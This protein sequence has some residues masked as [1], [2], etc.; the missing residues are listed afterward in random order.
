MN[1]TLF[2]KEWKSSYKLLLI[3]AAILTMYMSVMIVMFDPGL[4]SALD[5]F[6]KAMPEMMAMF[7][8]SNAGATLV[9]FLSTYLY[10]ML[11]IVFPM[12]F[13]VI[14][15]VRLI[16][17]QVDKGF[18]AYLL[19]SPNARKTVWTTQFLV[20]LTNIIALLVYITTLGIVCSMFMFPGELDIPAFIRLNLGVLCLHLFF[21][22]FSFLVSCIFNE[23]RNATFLASGVPVLF[24]L[25]QMLA[26]MGGNLENL[27]YITILTLFDQTGLIAKSGSAA[28]S[29]IVLLVLA[30]ICFVAAN[31]I[32]RK[33][34][35]PL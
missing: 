31:I 8:M 33:K 29:A 13:T 12:I 24:L 7:G 9:D 30:V 11:L 27:K 28:L 2:L 5:E 19:A 14:L 1:R 10:G 23:A 35:M 18:M 15:A 17:R 16:V 3:F 34:D 25:I 21:A 22:G 26:N 4:G 20:L 32:F 6:S